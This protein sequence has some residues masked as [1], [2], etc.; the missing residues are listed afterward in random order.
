MSQPSDLYDVLA[1]SSLY[2]SIDNYLS[3][4]E[5]KNFVIGRV[6]LFLSRSLSW[7]VS[8]IEAYLM[9]LWRAQEYYSHD[10]DRIWSGVGA[11]PEHVLKREARSGFAVG[12]GDVTVDGLVRVYDA[13]DSVLRPPTAGQDW[14]F[15]VIVREG[16]GMVWSWLEHK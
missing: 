14:L 8:T 13:L 11:A 7:P 9:T 4:L 10:V 6:A 1:D 12:M 5:T 2:T 3:S 16:L 15:R